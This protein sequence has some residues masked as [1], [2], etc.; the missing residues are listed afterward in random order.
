MRKGDFHVG[1]FRGRGL[2][3]RSAVLCR[4]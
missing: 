4:V 3:P 2:H 1:L